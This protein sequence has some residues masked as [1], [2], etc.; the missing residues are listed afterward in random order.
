M[1]DE[2]EKLD[3]D[4]LA[5]SAEADG[6]DVDVELDDNLDWGSDLS[7]EDDRSP[8]EQLG[9]IYDVPVQVSAVLGKAAMPIGQLIKLGRGAILELDRKVGESVDIVVNNRL[10]ARGEVVIV[11]ER[12][13]ITLTEIIKS[14]S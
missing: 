4:D 13:G 8:A 1:T 5:K 2:K 7:D 12:I 3:L 9:A 11:D 14:E 10:V 6:A